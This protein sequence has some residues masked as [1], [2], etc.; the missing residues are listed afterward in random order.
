[1]ETLLRPTEDLIYSQKFDSHQ[2]SI[3]HQMEEE[4]SYQMKDSPFFTTEC[5]EWI[6]ELLQVGD[7][8]GWV[9]ENNIVIPRQITDVRFNYVVLDADL[10][11]GS[12][13]VRHKDEIRIDD[14]L[15]YEVHD[16]RF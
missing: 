6:W 15:F 10:N 12:Q 5:E 14:N 13:V 2:E 7:I 9:N 8:V 11:H 1:M 4:L 16:E 3:K